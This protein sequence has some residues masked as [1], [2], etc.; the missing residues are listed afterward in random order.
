MKNTPFLFKGQ[1]SKKGIIKARGV[2]NWGCSDLLQN[3]MWQI[4][5]YN[6]L[7]HFISTNN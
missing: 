2:A 4:G 7:P 1:I 3:K 6:Q 5:L